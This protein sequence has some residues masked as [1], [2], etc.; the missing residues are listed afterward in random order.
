MWERLENSG[1]EWHKS[2]AG[3][4]LCLH[5]GGH[6]GAETKET[7]ARRQIPGGTDRWSQ[8][9]GQREAGRDPKAQE[10]VHRK[11]D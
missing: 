9:H 1:Q 11:R 6:R 3:A 7:K 10:E 5:V 8:R 2:T 4:E